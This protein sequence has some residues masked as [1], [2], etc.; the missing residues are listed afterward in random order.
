MLFR[1]PRISPKRGFPGLWYASHVFAIVRDMFCNS[2]CY[3]GLEDISAAY[4]ITPYFIR[5]YKNFL[6]LRNLPLYW[7][8]LYMWNGFV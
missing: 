3:K 7:S 8:I 4:V 6:I 5:V 2:L 1:P